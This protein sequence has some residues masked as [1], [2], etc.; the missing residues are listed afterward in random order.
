MGTLWTSRHRAGIAGSGQ[1]DLMEH[2]LRPGQQL[3]PLFRGWLPL[4]FGRHLFA[5]ALFDHPFPDFGMPLGQVKRGES[6][7]VQSPLVFLGGVAFEAELTQQG[8][9]GL[10]EV[11]RGVKGGLGIERG[12]ETRPRQGNK[13]VNGGA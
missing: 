11:S 3:L 9:D 13:Q 5:F 8:S 10:V 6:F 12:R 2:G 7:E 4:V 1:G